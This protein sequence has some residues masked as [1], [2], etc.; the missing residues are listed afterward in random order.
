MDH[1]M[2]DEDDIDEDNHTGTDNDQQQPDSPAITNVSDE[3][4]ETNHDEQE[5]IQSSSHQRKRM[6]PLTNNRCPSSS[7]TNGKSDLLSVRTHLEKGKMI[8]IKKLF[9]NLFL[10]LYVNLIVLLYQKMNI[11]MMNNINL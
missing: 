7:I 5:Q 9:V 6:L 10:K 8:F 1:E 3:L 2:D 4:L 11:M